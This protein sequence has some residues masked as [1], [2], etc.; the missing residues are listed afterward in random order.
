M[1]LCNPVLLTGTGTGL[2]DVAA[3]LRTYLVHT[4]EMT[5]ARLGDSLQD[6][7]MRKQIAN[8]ISWDRIWAIRARQLHVR[9]PT[10]RW[11]LESTIADIGTAP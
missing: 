8:S 5:S 3:R 9:H 10:C 4:R 1:D 6:A 11:Q 2:A 7:S